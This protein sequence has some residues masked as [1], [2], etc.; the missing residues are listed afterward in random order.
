MVIETR[1]IATK[2]EGFDGN[3]YSV[4]LRLIPITYTYDTYIIPIA[5]YLKFWFRGLLLTEFRDSS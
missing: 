2:L 1:A 3:W 4:L 5:Y